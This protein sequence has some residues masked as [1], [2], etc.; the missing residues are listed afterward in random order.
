MAAPRG[1]VDAD[2]LARVARSTG[3]F[4]GL[5]YQLMQVHLGDSVLDVGCGSGED[6]LHLA[7]LVGPSG[8]VEG[9]DMDAGLLRVARRRAK[10]LRLAN[11]AHHRTTLPR[12]PFPD[13]SFDAV[14]S[15]RVFQHLQ[16]PAESLRECVRVLRPHGRL[17]I[18]EPDWGTLV[19]DA[20]D[21]RLERSVLSRGIDGAMYNAT[22]GRRLFGDFVRAGLEAIE[23]QVHPIRYGSLAAADE[24]ILRGLEA[25]ARKK[26]GA[27]AM[28]RWRKALELAQAEGRFF[29]GFN[30][31]IV[32]GRVGA[33][34]VP[35]SRPA[36]RKPRR[37]A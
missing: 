9:V 2:Y 33:H 11:V 6:T 23:V 8:R 20:G 34:D 10:A 22:A 7:E 24:F 26:I 12:L 14:R 21:P 3:G 18:L 4:K 30:Y 5:T 28:A 16:Y 37:A 35:P 19:V 1:Y 13:R 17:V 29:A 27:R 15:E 36:G 25:V 31:V 32:S